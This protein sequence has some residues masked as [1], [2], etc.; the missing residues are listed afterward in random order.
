MM[1]LSEPVLRGRSTLDR[2]I[3]LAYLL[4]ISRRRVTVR[5]VQRDC[6]KALMLLR[7][8]VERFD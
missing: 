6:A 5:T 7:P 2:L 4:G 1:G 3:P 8:A